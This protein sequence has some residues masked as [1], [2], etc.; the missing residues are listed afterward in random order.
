MRAKLRSSNTYCRFNVWRK[1]VGREKGRDVIAQDI[2]PLKSVMPAAASGREFGEQIFRDVS[3][4]ASDGG[5]SIRARQSPHAMRRDVSVCRVFFVGLFARGIRFDRALAR[6][7]GQLWVVDVE[8]RSA[9]KTPFASG[10][11]CL[12][13]PVHQNPFRDSRLD[14]DFDELVEDLIQLLPKI[15][16]IVQ[17]GEDKGLECN[18]R[19]VGEVFEHRLVGFHSRVSVRQPRAQAPAAGKSR[20]YGISI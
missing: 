12:L 9:L 11:R 5:A 19:A 14:V 1:R 20:I 7:E 6:Q 18:F 17:A 3:K 13:L 16:A 2:D 8:R 10:L 15:G 4:K